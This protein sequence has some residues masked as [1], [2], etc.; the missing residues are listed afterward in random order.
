MGKVIQKLNG[1]SWHGLPSAYPTCVHHGYDMLSGKSFQVQWHQEG[2]EAESP[3][4]DISFDFNSDAHFSSID[5]SQWQL[6]RVSDY[7]N[8]YSYSNRMVDFMTYMLISSRSK[9]PQSTSS[10]KNTTEKEPLHL[11]MSSH[12]N[13]LSNSEH[14]PSVSIPKS[15]QKKGMGLGSFTFLTTINKVHC[16]HPPPQKKNLSAKADQAYKRSIIKCKF[17]V[18]E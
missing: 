6:C 1:K 12:P 14:F 16:N 5:C 18:R 7:D 10:R 8:E 9:K 3:L 17:P 4:K 15:P 2:K 13:T 11:L